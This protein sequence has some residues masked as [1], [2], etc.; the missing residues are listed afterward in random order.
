[1]AVM[2]GMA[3]TAT[4]RVTDTANTSIAAGMDTKAAVTADTMAE[5]MAGITGV[6]NDITGMATTKR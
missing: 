2:V 3:A 1:M 5:D 4:D 6:T